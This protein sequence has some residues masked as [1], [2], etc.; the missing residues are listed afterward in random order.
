M[1]VPRMNPT[2]LQSIWYSK[3]NDN[4]QLAWDHTLSDPASW[5][6][7]VSHQQWICT[8]HF[9]QMTGSTDWAPRLDSLQ[10]LC[11]H[12]LKSLIYKTK[13]KNLK[14]PLVLL[15]CIRKKT[16][17][18]FQ[19]Q[20]AAQSERSWGVGCIWS[21]TFPQQ[22]LLYFFSFMLPT[23]YIFSCVIY[24]FSQVAGSEIWSFC[25]NFYRISEDLHSHLCSLRCHLSQ[26]K[27][28]SAERRAEPEP[29]LPSRGTKILPHKSIPL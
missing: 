9:P 18:S 29:D 17:I 13:P 15:S 28:F 11:K 27:H 26:Q 19:L 21:I 23:S 20:E 2:S 4:K 14:K 8:P 1:L 22:W 25:G 16:L 6:P 5:V 10:L 12:A 7:G 24:S 3:H